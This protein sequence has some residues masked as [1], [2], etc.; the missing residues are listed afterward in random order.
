M[1][2]EFDDENVIEETPGIM[3]ISVP[4]KGLEITVDKGRMRVDTD[5][6]SARKK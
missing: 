2:K 1:L 4:S 3:H 5:A 6:T